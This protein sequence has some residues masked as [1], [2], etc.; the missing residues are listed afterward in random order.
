MFKDKAIIPYMLILG[1]L[2]LLSLITIAKLPLGLDEAYYWYWS[3]HPDLSYLDHPPMIAW[4]MTISTNVAG[5]QEFWV[6]SGG[7]LL[8]WGG[9]ILGMFTLRELFPYIPKILAWEYLLLL[10]LVPVFS[11]ATMIQ[12]PDTPLLAFWLLALY[13]GAKIVNKHDAKSWYVLGIAVG[14]GL[15]SK[16]TMVLFVM[17]MLLFLILAPTHRYWLRRPEPW[18]GAL[19]ALLIW[20]PVWIWNLEHAWISFKFQLHKGFTPDT[21]TIAER[22]GI[23]F[24]TQAIVIS[25]LIWLSCVGYS[26]KKIKRR[27]SNPEYLYLMA[28]SWPII[29]FFAW[30]TSRGAQAE[31]NWPAPAYLSGLMLAWITLRC[32]WP[33]DNVI[34][35]TECNHQ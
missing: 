26:L 21:N 14:L 10:N 31:A 8:L 24:A 12:M 18:I 16:Y 15:L 20:S 9:F 4:I 32:D 34:S 2:L 33:T 11:G 5:N 17:G 13:F 25:P 29:L 19:L 6:R 1:I 35:T 7:L 27:I 30:T 23:Y 3:Q 22:L 28:L